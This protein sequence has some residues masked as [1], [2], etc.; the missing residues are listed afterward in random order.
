MTKVFLIQTE[1]GIPD[2]WNDS[3][4]MSNVA[5]NPGLGSVNNNNAQAYESQMSFF[6]RVDNRFVISSS[7]HS[8]ADLILKKP[9]SVDNIHLG[10]QIKLDDIASMIEKTPFNIVLYAS[11]FNNVRN[12]QEA[13]ES[14]TFYSRISTGEVVNLKTNDIVENPTFIPWFF[15]YKTK[16]LPLYYIV[17]NPYSI[18]ITENFEGQYGENKVY[19]ISNHL[20]NISELIFKPKF[21]RNVRQIGDHNLVVRGDEFT[22]QPFDTWF[23]KKHFPDF[24]ENVAVKIDTNFEYSIADRKIKI[25]SLNKKRGFLSVR[26]NS[27]TLM[28]MTFGA[29]K[30]RFFKEYIVDF[31]E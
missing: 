29:S 31:I 14:A 16:D 20:K 21:S 11:P 5:V 18:Q 2:P 8:G 30:N 15:A 10:I 26:W 23:V 25:N 4:N 19:T 9:Y 27:G 12:H 13:V 3:I 24:F 17:M 7:D 22:V 28:D 6:Q 1:M